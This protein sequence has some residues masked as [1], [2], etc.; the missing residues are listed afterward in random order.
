[1]IFGLRYRYIVPVH[2]QLLF[3]SHPRHNDAAD[4][5][6]TA[7]LRNTYINYRSVSSPMDPINFPD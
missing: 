4:L 3:V 7:M 2:A 1:M 5:V 6:H